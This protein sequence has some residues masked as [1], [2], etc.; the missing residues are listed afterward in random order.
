MYKRLLVV[1]AGLS[2]LAGCGG[3]SS[4]GGGSGY[5]GVTTQATVTTSN[6][7]A[8]SADAYT[9]T[10]LSSSVSVAKATVDENNKSALLQETAAILE[11]SVAAIVGA[12]KSPAKV[13]SASVQQTISGF[14]GSFSFSI[15]LDQTSG[16][17]NG[18]LTFTQYKETSTSATL[19]GVINFSGVYNQTTDTFTS[20]NMSMSSLTGTY[21]GRSYTL[22]GNMTFSTSGSTKTETIS[23]VLIDNASSRTY[24]MKDFT[25]TL[26]GNS[27]TISGTYYDPIHG[28]VVIRTET[29]LTVS[30][31]DATP[32]SGQ[33]LFTG[34]NGTKARLTFTSGGFTVDADTTGT[35]TF[36]VVP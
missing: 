30:A 4:T 29:P 2:L 32:T 14:S 23:V 27:L 25:Q 10:Q 7:K 26:T 21:G 12:P 11:N 35:G 3:S 5:T 36:V 22:S 19:N 15:N 8:L 17:F 13:V 31:I 34:S 24:W 28:F 33:L 16:A 20:M 18:T 1:L 9:G 6:A